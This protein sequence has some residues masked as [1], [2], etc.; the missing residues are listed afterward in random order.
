MIT[1]EIE[2]QFYE[3]NRT[4]TVPF[5]INDAVEI[6]E[7]EY[8]G[9]SAAVISIEQIEPELIYLIELGDGA[10]DVVINGKWMKLA[11]V[12]TD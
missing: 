4:S 1:K 8:K 2:K 9:K 12:S 7:G 11:E 5:I 10:G 3:G 6:I